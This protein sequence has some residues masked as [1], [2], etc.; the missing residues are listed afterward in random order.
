M[1][2]LL[3]LLKNVPGSLVM[4]DS[5]ILIDD[6]LKEIGVGLNSPPFLKGKCQFHPKEG[7]IGM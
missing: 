5:V 4:A 1:Y 7:T 3:Q 2:G 6:H